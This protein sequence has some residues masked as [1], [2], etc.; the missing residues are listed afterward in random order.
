M[1]RIKVVCTSSS[2]FSQEEAQRLNID[3]ISIPFE[4][5][6]I[7]YRDS[8]DVSAEIFYDMITT[9]EINQYNIPKTFSPFRSEIVTIVEKAIFEEYTDILFITVSQKLGSAYNKIRLDCE[10]FQDRIGIHLFDSKTLGYHEQKLILL[11]LDLIKEGFTLPQILEKLS[12]FRENFYLFG[13][14][15]DLTFP[16]YNGRLKG[17]QAF[18]GKNLPIYGALTL[19]EEGEI[20]SFGKSF[21]KTKVFSMAADR[22][23]RI[24]DSSPSEYLLWRFMGNQKMRYLLEKAENQVGLVPNL[25]DTT[26]PPSIGVHSGPYIGGWGLIKI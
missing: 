22:V 9:R 10:D 20:I 21:H 8:L 6:G 2:G 3:I 17:G 26:L 24:I 7:Q 23:K 11:A 14:C 1:Q 15:I 12:F 18:L 19:S 4:F 5:E 16:I 25:A 13:G